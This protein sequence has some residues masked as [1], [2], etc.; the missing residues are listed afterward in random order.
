[1]KAYLEAVKSAFGA[2]IDFGQL[3]KICG[4]SPEGEVRYSPAECTGIKKEVIMGYPV[5]RDISTSHVERQNL[6][7]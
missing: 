5:K 2:D 7:M 4:A 1:M 3:V 6:T